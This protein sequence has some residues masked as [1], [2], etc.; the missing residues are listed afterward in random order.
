MTKSPQNTIS[1]MQFPNTCLFWY[2]HFTVIVVF[3]SVILFT[4]VCDSTSITS[5]SNGVWWSS[6]RGWVFI[7][8]K[9]HTDR[10]WRLTTC[11]IFSCCTLECER[12]FTAAKCRLTAKAQL[13][14]DFMACLGILLHIFHVFVNLA[15]HNNPSNECV[16]NHQNLE[17]SSYF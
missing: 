9:K 3:C 14:M 11:W 7:C 8:V 16:E 17:M 6:A 2:F 4:F 10:L 5:N 15:R 1:I 13:K 12:N